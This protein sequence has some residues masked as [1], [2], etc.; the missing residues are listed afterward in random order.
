MNKVT[1]DYFMTLVS[2]NNTP[3]TE[4]F[5]VIAELKSMFLSLRLEENGAHAKALSL[6]L[7][8]GNSK[9]EIRHKKR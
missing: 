9:N 7:A 2:F 8:H 1:S 5:T 3:F 4:M 6:T